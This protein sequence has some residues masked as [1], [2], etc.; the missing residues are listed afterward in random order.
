VLTIDLLI[1]RYNL[2]LTPIKKLFTHSLP[3]S[4]EVLKR[5]TFS[6]FTPEISSVDGQYFSASTNE[7]R[8]A[9]L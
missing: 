4:T 8:T 3:Q 5:L 9:L 2:I 7:T 1:N 6:L